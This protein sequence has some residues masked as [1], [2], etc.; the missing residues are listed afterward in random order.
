MSNQDYEFIKGFTGFAR[1]K[2]KCLEDAEDIIHDTVL[3]IL[4]NPSTFD[5][6]VS[7]NEKKNFVMRV[8]KNTYADNIKKAS[9]SKRDNK[10][11]LNKSV[12]VNPSI[13]SIIELKEIKQ[14]ALT[15][16]ELNSL[17]MSAEGYLTSDISKI[18]K[19]KNNAVLA[20]IFRARKSL[21]EKYA[22]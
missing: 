5:T 2:C 15:N 1:S 3:K 18:I 14:A 17:F 20:Q 8:I 21:R 19:K 4:K 11:W 6:I 16:K 12:D 13:Y 9:A 7:I 22:H 10:S